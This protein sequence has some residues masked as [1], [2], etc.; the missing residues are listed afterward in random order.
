MLESFVSLEQ[1]LTDAGCDEDFIEKFMI[2]TEER[3]T[4]EM[5]KMLAARR[6][7]LLDGIHDDERRIYCLDYLVNRLS[8][9]R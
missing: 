9:N 2:L 7:T 4:A 6:K 3:R 8:E 5:L 1:N